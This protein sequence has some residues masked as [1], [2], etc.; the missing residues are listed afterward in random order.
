MNPLLATFFNFLALSVGCLIFRHFTKGSKMDSLPILVAGGAGGALVAIA[1]QTLIGGSPEGGRTILGGVLGGWFAVE[2]VK[3]KLGVRESTGRAW[4]LALTAG[5]AIGRIGCFF[6]GCCYGKVSSRQWSVY[7]HG[8]WRYPTQFFSSAA[9]ICLF[10]FIL[11]SKSLKNPFAA[12]IL[13]WAMAR[14]G[15]EFYREPI[16]P[17]GVLTLAQMTCVGLIAYSIPKLIQAKSLEAD[18]A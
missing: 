7:Q 5:E 2:I 8:H 16:G 13:L 12:Y 3:R 4:A 9:A 6:N 14:F 17:G 11:R 18:P 10:L 1:A 15:I